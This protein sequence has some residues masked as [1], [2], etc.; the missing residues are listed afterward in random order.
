MSEIEKK[1][2]PSNQEKDQ[3]EQETK[4]IQCFENVTSLE[5]DETRKIRCTS[6]TMGYPKDTLSFI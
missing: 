6:K 1:E 2:E 4:V 3:E 5:W